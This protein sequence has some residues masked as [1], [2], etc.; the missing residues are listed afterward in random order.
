MYVSDAQ[1]IHAQDTTL[2]IRRW[3]C[4]CSWTYFV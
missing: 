3:R 1:N 2:K 4:V